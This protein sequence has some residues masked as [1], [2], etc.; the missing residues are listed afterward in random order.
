MFH[1]DSLT[2]QIYRINKT[3]TGFEIINL[4]ND[5][6]KAIILKELIAL[7]INTIYLLMF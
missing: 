3:E 1:V 5:D 4:K 6:L 7:I 2:D